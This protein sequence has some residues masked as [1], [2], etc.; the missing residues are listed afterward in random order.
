[1]K[2]CGNI[3]L[4]NEKLLSLLNLFILF[5][6]FTLIPPVMS[7]SAQSKSTAVIGFI[8]KG[9]LDSEMNV[10]LT[11][12][13]ISFFSRLPGSKIIPFDVSDKAARDGGFFDKKGPDTDLAVRI[14][15]TLRCRQVVFGS[16]QT[17]AKQ[18][19]IEINVSAYDT[20]SGEVIFKRRYEGN[21]GNSLLDTI[22]NVRRD[23]AV[24]LAGKDVPMTELKIMATNTTAAYDVFL[25]GSP[26][27]TASPLYSKEL[28]AGSLFDL[29]LRRKTDGLEVFRTNILLTKD[30]DVSIDY[31]PTAPVFIQSSVC[32][33]EVW[34]DGGKTGDISQKQTFILNGLPAGSYYRFFLRNKELETD[35]RK[36]YISEGIPSALNFDANNFH[37]R[38][39]YSGLS[40]AWDLLLPGLVQI[41]AH[42]YW[43]ALIFGGLWLADAG[44]CAYCVYGYFV[45]D[46]IVRNDPRSYYRDQI[47]PYRDFYL[48]ASLITGGFWIALAAGSWFYAEQMKAIQ[49]KSRDFSFQIIPAG[50]GLALNLNYYIK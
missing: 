38:I 18:M 10:L 9:P 16:Y 21:T 20:A 3:F 39:N 49:E 8:N 25:G 50:S 31:Y 5:L 41:Q 27:G 1:M 19:K 30:R 33:A 26:D 47:K 34:Y 6:S 48:P 42:D 28:P 45:S 29:T 14:G 17:D 37:P 12:S 40:P 2:A 11:R 35:V 4:N 43:M 13:F 7:F 32:P 22:D 23:T 24:L 36:I 44:I 15:Q 46:N